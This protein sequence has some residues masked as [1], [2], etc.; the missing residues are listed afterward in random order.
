MRRRHYLR[1]TGIKARHLAR[2]LIRPFKTYLVINRSRI[3][4]IA[5]YPQVLLKLTDRALLR[6]CEGCKDVKLIRNLLQEA[7]LQFAV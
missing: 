3:E 1:K 7:K 2:K 4:W 6:V 5:A